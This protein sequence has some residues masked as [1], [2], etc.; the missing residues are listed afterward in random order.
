MSQ[1]SGEET[2]PRRRPLPAFGVALGHQ[3]RRVRE[4]SEMTAEAL[5]GMSRFVGLH[6]DRSTVTRIELGQRQVTAAELVAL[7]VLYGKPLADLLPDETCQVTPEMAATPEA[8]RRI[9]V[10]HSPRGGVQFGA[11]FWDEFDRAKAKLLQTARDFDARYPKVPGMQV[12][13]AARYAKDEAITKAA[14]K[15]NVEPLDVAIA[16]IQTFDRSLTEERDA[17][18]GEHGTMRARQAKRGHVTRQLLEELRPA[19]AEIQAARHQE[20]E[21]NG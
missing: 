18:V 1:S 8:L 21:R 12:M 4:N 3:L 20:E 2:A 14:R 9:L 5:A 7:A 11:E 6:W 15:L 10:G 19:L 13:N 16:S 17:R